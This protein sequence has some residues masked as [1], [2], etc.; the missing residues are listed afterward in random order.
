MNTSR[1]ISKRFWCW[2]F[3][4]SLSVSAFAQSPA[5]SFDEL[6]SSLT[7]HRGETIKI[8]ETGGVEFKAQLAQISEHSIVVS[9]KNSRR[10]LSES[11]VARIVH[12]R[13]DVWWNGMLVGMGVGAATGGVL[14]S[15]ACSG[16]GDC[17]GPAVASGITVFAVMGGIYFLR[18]EACLPG[19]EKSGKTAHRRRRIKASDH[20]PLGEWYVGQHRHTS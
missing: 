5:A 14:A 2:S 20:R 16:Y 7:L 18:I 1:N 11:T 6:R 12:R 19:F 17:Y 8:T 9:V 10:E 4:F 15:V 13:P 3:V